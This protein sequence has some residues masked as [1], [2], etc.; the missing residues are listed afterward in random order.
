MA[1]GPLEVPSQMLIIRSG[2]NQSEY[3]AGI[4]VRH[5]PEYAK[6]IADSL[7]DEVDLLLVV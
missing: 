7:L 1:K 4:S 5:G 6:S 2:W 3:P